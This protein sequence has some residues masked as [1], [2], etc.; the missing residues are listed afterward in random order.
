MASW[1]YDLSLRKVEFADVKRIV[2]IDLFSDTQYK[3]HTVD[4]ILKKEE[5]FLTSNFCCVLNVLCSLLGDSPASEVWHLNYR[6][7]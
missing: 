7:R 4:K 1:I 3:H 6:H 2:S 5:F